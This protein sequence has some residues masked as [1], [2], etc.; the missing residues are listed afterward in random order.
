MM[1]GWVGGWEKCAQS[2]K[3]GGGEGGLVSWREARPPSEDGGVGEGGR[4]VRKPFALKTRKWERA[5]GGCGCT[6]HFRTT[7]GTS[8]S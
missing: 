7:L 8:A 3:T 5:S 4:V 1:G 2:P 6:K